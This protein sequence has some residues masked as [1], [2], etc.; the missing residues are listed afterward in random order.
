ML[1]FDKSLENR[2]KTF[3][4]MLEGLILTACILFNEKLE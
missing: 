2:S 3:L 1:L 4:R